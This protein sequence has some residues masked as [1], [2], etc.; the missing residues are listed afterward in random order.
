MAELLSNVGT[1]Q[2]LLVSGFNDISA[3]GALD[4]VRD[5]RRDK[6]VAIV[7]HNAMAEGRT[8]IRKR[9]SA[10]IAS[11]AYFPER[12]GEKLVKLA[13]AIADGDAV[14]PAAYTDHLVIDRVNV[15][16]LYPEERGTTGMVPTKSA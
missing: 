14:P 11:V 2:R 13:R 10:F 12:Y 9:D 4:A 15:H 8:E 16:R 1:E 6:T 7:D 5:A 3:I